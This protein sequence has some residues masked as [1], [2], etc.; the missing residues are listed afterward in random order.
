MQIVTLS[1]QL[2]S[3]P[4]LLSSDSTECSGEKGYRSVLASHPIIE[5][6]F[7]FEVKIL[8][9]LLPLPFIG[10]EPH[11]R[12][13][14]ATKKVDINLPIGCDLYG[15]AYGDKGELIHGSKKLKCGKDYHIGDIV[16][17][18]IH[19]VPPKPP[20]LIEKKRKK[21]EE[22]DKPISMAVG[23]GSYLKFYINGMPQNES[24]FFYDLF[25]GIGI[26]REILCWDIIIYACESKIECWAKI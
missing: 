15:Y 4:L 9:P 11:V 14:I 17:V 7:Y 5:G 25:E 26:N 18:C 21:S 10:V 20:M 24:T 23:K 13:G 3:P 8:P 12:I 1:N 2:K 22:S 19:L 6:D 16:G